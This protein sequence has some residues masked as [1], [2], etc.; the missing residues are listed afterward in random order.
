LFLENSIPLKKSGVGAVKKRK[1]GIKGNS[2]Q[3][4]N[5]AGEKRKFFSI[6]GKK[7]EPNEKGRWGR[8]K[9][10][11]KRTDLRKK[12]RR[13]IYRKSSLALTGKKVWPEKVSQGTGTARHRRGKEKP[14]L[15]ESSWEIYFRR[16][17]KKEE[18]RVL[19]SLK[20]GSSGGRPPRK[21]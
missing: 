9:R 1:L 2:H 5:G 13:K 8:K 19:L 3:D 17:K 11:V 6:A 21:K 18:E 4:G 15:G 7:P 14:L 10:D 16:T 20:N 12:E